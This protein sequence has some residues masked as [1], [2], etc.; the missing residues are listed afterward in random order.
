MTTSQGYDDL[1]I[2]GDFNLEPNYSRMKS[3]LNIN[4]CT[5]LIKTNTCFN[6]AGSSIDFIL[7]NRTYSF[8]YTIS[9]ETGL[10]DP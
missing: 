4:R 8:Q 2:M 10:S 9:Y 5:N 3:L 1:L 6:G 7:T